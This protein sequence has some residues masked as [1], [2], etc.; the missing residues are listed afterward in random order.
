LRRNFWKTDFQK[1]FLIHFFIENTW[2][3][4]NGKNES[5]SETK[6]LRGRNES[7]Y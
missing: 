1:L 4:V 2:K 6:G 7:L 3:F 5:G